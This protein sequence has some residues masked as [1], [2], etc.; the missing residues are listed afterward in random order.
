[1]RG[2]PPRRGLPLLI[3]LARQEADACRGELARVLAHVTELREALARHDRRA[4]AEAR[5]VAADAGL[6]AAYPGW[7]LR[8]A[9]HRSELVVR[10]DA[11]EREEARR[12][13]ALREAFA[14]TKRL[15]LVAAADEADTT[16]SAA[17]RAQA[18]AE[19]RAGLRGGFGGAED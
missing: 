12:R 13:D 8:D 5:V 3:R 10:L 9:R 15:E 6:R 16:R 14:A 11:A 7:L 4:E 19:E 2:N 1:M 17:R 18:A